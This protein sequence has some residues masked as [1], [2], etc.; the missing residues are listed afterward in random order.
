[1]RTD[2]DFELEKSRDLAGLYGTRVNSGPNGRFFPLIRKIKFTV[3]ASN[4]FGWEHVSV[5]PWDLARTP[6]WDEMCVVKNWFWTPE[7]AVMQLHPPAEDYV[8]YHPY[9]LHLWRPLLQEIPLPPWQMVG[10]KK[11]HHH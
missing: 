3:L 6:T 2:L 4:G 8:N 7:E 5:S 10:P 1:M 9:V 11:Y